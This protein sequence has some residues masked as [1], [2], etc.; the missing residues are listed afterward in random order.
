VGRPGGTEAALDAGDHQVPD[1]LARDAGGG[2]LPAENLALAS[3]G[4]EQ[5]ADDAGVTTGDLEVVRTPAD[6]RAERHDGAVVGPAGPAGG[7]GLQGE[8]GG[9]QGAE[10]ALAVDRRLA[11]GRDARG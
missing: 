3:V 6:V 8:A 1:D 11:A 10:H 9:A 2:G 4:G 7:V 5:H